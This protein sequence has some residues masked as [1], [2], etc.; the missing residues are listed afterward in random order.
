VVVGR[1]IGLA[2]TITCTLVRVSNEELDGV[3]LDGHVTLVER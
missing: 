1:L 3:T 2:Q